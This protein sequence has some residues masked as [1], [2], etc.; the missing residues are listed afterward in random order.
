M[1][2]LW[3][4]RVFSSTFLR[5]QANITTVAPTDVTIVKKLEGSCS[6]EWPISC[7]NQCY[8]ANL[9][10]ALE[11]MLFMHSPVAF[12]RNKYRMKFIRTS[13]ADNLLTVISATEG[14]LPLL[15]WSLLQW[16]KEA[17]SVLAQTC[18]SGSNG[19]VANVPLRMYLCVCVQYLGIWIFRSFAF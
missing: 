12:C 16:T 9:V 4:L 10:I 11:R 8:R 7:S 2:A 18:S 6:S 1:L 5:H 15:Q 3:F 13:K 14:R 19:F 17:T